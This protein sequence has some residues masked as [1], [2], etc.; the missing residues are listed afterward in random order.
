MR[1]GEMKTRLKARTFTA[2]GNADVCTPPTRRP[3]KWVVVKHPDGV[4]HGS[5]RW[6]HSGGHQLTKIQ[7]VHTFSGQGMSPGEANHEEQQVE[8][9]AR[10]RGP[11]VG[12]WLV[13]KDR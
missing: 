9:T 6:S 7:G 8:G 1:L 10:C 2:A 5:R 4:R 3:H 13:H 12:A 11:E